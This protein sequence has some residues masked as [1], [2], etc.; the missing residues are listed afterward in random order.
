MINVDCMNTQMPSRGGCQR[1][2]SLLQKNRVPTPENIFTFW[3]IRLKLFRA[4]RNLNTVNSTTSFYKIYLFV[5]WIWEKEGWVGRCANIL[6]AKK[7]F[8]IAIL[9]YIFSTFNSSNWNHA[10]STKINYEVHVVVRFMEY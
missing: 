3:N 1:E 4:F 6:F 10:T 8:L 5:H 9:I 2:A 7:S